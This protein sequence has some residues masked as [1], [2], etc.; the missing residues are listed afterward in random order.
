MVLILK[1]FGH[2]TYKIIKLSNFGYSSDCRL[3]DLIHPEICYDYIN[4]IQFYRAVIDYLIVD[5]HSIRGYESDEV[6]NTLHD[7]IVRHFSGLRIECYLV[8]LNEQVFPFN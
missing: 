7:R 2:K 8:E 6:T 1:I 3:T 4:R 5:G